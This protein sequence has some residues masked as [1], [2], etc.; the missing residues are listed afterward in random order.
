[1]ELR[2]NRVRINRARPVVFNAGL[3]VA[4]A[5]EFVRCKRGHVVTELFNVAVS[6][7]DAKE[8][9]RCNRTHCKRDSL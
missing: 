3:P 5:N 8:S 1:M 2:I 6:D 7:F 4:T 9:V